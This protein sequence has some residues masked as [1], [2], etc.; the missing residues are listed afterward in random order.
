MLKINSKSLLVVL[1][2]I[3]VFLV[4]LLYNTQVRLFEFKNQVSKLETTNQEFTQRLT[5]DSLV[6]AEQGQIILGQKDAI[7]LGLLE[8]DRLKKVKSQ[9]KTI[10]KIQIDSVVV[11]YLDTLRL[12]DTVYRKGTINVPKRF[13]VAQDHYTLGGLV[14]LNDVMFD[15]VLVTNEMKI[16]IGQKNNGFFKKTTPIVE[17]E[18]SNPYIN[19]VDM[20]NVVIENKKRIYERPL[21]WAGVGLLGGIIIAK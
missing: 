5:K 11:P 20:N 13:L 8:V 18:N 2:C 9:V 16:T 4:W 10:T 19:V 1:A 17:V 3:V 12:T 15:S 6:I 7:R 14:R 21:F